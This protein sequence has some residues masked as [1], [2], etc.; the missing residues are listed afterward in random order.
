MTP[1]KRSTLF[2]VLIVAA[3]WMPAT[4]ADDNTLVGAELGYSHDSNFLASPADVP[5][6]PDSS[7]TLSA[8]LGHYWPTSDLK[9]ALMLRG[10]A[11][12]VRQRTFTTL[13][14]TDFGASIG[15]YHA[16]STRS[17]MTVSVSELTRHFT[18]ATF[19]SNTRSLQ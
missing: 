11:G 10:E 18:D 15:Y 12:L 5:S 4:R 8:Y 17:V 16:F 14:S 13:D 9:D 1:A 6:T 3:G 19:D 7:T 2:A